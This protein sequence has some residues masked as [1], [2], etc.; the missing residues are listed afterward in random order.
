MSD[1]KN[2]TDVYSGDLPVDADLGEEAEEP[3]ENTTEGETHE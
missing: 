3:T 1:P 2:E